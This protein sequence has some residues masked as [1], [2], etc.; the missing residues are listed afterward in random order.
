MKNVLEL[1]LY[2]PFPLPSGEALSQEHEKLNKGFFKNSPR[3]FTRRS[4][5]HIVII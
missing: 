5:T 3:F 1:N 4:I 2:L